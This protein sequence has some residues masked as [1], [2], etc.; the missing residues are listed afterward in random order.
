MMA[1]VNRD[2]AYGGMPIGH[3]NYQGDNSRVYGIFF[4]D[5]FDNAFVNV[6]GGSRIISIVNI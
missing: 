1:P 3:L 5:D 2:L 6:Y 4:D